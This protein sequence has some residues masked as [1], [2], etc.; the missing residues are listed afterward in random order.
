MKKFKIS[1]VLVNFIYKHVSNT[2]FLSPKWVEYHTVYIL[3]GL[4]ILH[5]YTDCEEES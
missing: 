5:Y 2:H 4:I 3:G 1:S